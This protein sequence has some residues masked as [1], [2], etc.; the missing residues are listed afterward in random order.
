MADSDDDLLTESKR[1]MRITYVFAAIALA[2]FL[3]A[4]SVTAMSAAIR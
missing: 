2:M 3:L 1:K 4:A